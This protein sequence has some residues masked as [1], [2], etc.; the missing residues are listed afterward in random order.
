MTEQLP[1]PDE[2]SATS[3]TQGS[4][5]AVAGR[6]G[7]PQPTQATGESTESAD[8]L[9]REALSEAAGGGL[10]VPPRSSLYRPKT[11]VR[12]IKGIVSDE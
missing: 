5:Y 8:A 4:V 2:V 7:R 3:S 11:R 1:S 6:R 10:P 12:V 9:A